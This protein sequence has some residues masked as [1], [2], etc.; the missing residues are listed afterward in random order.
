M[1]EEY[2]WG[3]CLQCHLCDYHIYRGVNMSSHLN[4]KHTNQEDYWVEPL[5][6][7]DLSSSTKIH[8]CWLADIKEEPDCAQ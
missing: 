2:T 6:N 4:K 8:H 1:L 7:V 3:T 5:P